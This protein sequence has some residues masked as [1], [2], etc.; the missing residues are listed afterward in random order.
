MDSQI[1]K[2]I[3]NLSKEER[4]DII[5]A[6]WLSLNE[7]LQNSEIPEWHKNILDERIKRLK[8]GESVFRD[9]E[10]IKKKYI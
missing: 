10:D 2:V 8:T 9:W 6:I 7:E 5:D 1:L 4:L 3:L